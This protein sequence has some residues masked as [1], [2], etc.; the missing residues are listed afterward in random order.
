MNVFII[1]IGTR[2]DLEM[3]L[4]L[5]RELSLRGHQVNFGTPRFYSERV[6]E[7]KLDWQQIGYGTQEELL[8]VLRSLSTIKNTT[9]RTRQYYKRWL[10]P[11][12]DSATSQ[13]NSA[14]GA[15]DYFISNL[16]MALHRGS[17][18]IPGA[19]VDYDP[20]ADLSMLSRYGAESEEHRRTTLD[21]V[22][23]NRQLI[24]PE[25]RWG[26]Q[27]QF[28]GFWVD[29][30][31]RHW[32]PTSPLQKFMEDGTPPVVLT[33]GSMVM[34]DP[35]RLA[36][37]LMD[38]LENSKERGVIVGGWSGISEETGLSESVYTVNDVS[39]DW[40]FPRAR[41]VIHHG[42]TGTTAAVLRAGIPSI[43]LPQIVCQER[44]GRT[45]F[46][47]NLAAAV[48]DSHNLQ[49]EDLARAIQ[50]AATDARCIESARHWKNVIAAE[51]GVKNA[52]DFIERHWQKIQEKAAL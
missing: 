14:A 13:V 29:R 17:Q 50:R 34:F 8:S 47:E 39:Y 44:Y 45:L 3:F 38:A 23:M 27:Y 52:A 11:Q 9:E 12:I 24:D 22:A 2:G 6:L 25:A 30:E 35:V 41:C 20:P 49:T 51:D 5:G 32:V 43:L 16:K 33:M 48:L 42:G 7:S 26:E 18:R 46:R 10:Q 1:T 37:T 31:P 28:T 40:L 21:L 15:A 19:F 4:T 36:R